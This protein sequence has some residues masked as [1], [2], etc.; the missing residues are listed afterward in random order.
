M[1]LGLS[2]RLT[3]TGSS[4]LTMTGLTNGGALPGSHAGISVGFP[5]GVTAWTSQAWGVSS[6]GDTTYGTGSTPTD[7]TASDGLTLLWEGL[8]D[9]GNTY[10]AAAP[11]RYAPL[12]VNTA[13]TAS[14]TP[15]IGQTLTGTAA[16][17]S[18]TG[19]GGVTSEW[20]YSTDNVVWVGSGDTDTTSPTL[21]TVGRYWRFTSSET[22]SGGT[23][24]SSSSSIGPVA[25]TE[26]YLLLEDGSYLLLEDGS[27]IILE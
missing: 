20:E 16:T 22:N 7:F 24:F 12:T 26:S 6:F 5:A 1:H 11:I 23:T 3:G 4:L 13:A 25:D 18:G 17:F 2:L 27:R 10:R 19:G 9:D 21:G 15:T 14:G 8:G